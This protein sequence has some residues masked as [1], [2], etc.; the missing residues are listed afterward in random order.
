MVSKS[1]H[2]SSTTSSSTSTSTSPSSFI[3][4]Q[5]RPQEAT[6]LKKLP[7]ARVGYMEIDK[8]ATATGLLFY[9]STTA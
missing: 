1:D 2:P 9:F 8:L 5:N 7:K 3:S 6:K 4:T